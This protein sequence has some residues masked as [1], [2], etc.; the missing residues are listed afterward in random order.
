MPDDIAAAHRVRTADDALFPPIEARVSGRLKVSDLHD[1]YWEEAGSADGLP[2]V[3]L[4]GGPGAGISPKHRQFFD[5][6]A[7]RVVLHDQ[8]G[9]GR[10]TPFAEMTDNTTQHL[11]ADIERLRETRGIDKWVVFG[12]SWG[13]TLALAYAQAH[14]DRCLGLILRG[15][16]L[17][18]DSETDWFMYGLRELSPVAWRE[19][20]ALIPEAER[21]DLLGAY[22]RRLCD[23]DPAVNEPAGV[24][25]SLYEAR[26]STLY[27]EPALEAEMT[28]PAK[29]LA[30]SRIEAGYFVEKLFLE[31]GQLLRDVG[32]I[33]HLPA[34]IVQGRYDLL[35][36]IVAAEALHDAWPEAEY[37]LIPDAGH[38][39]FEPSIARALVA[40]TNRMAARLK[41]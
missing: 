38:S 13:S 10:S 23:P 16:F 36:P 1:L 19:F 21:G 4:H 26:S 3:F 41:A 22:Y 18:E 15:I 35:C 30:I 29:A 2:V 32:K 40:A 39:A 17:G 34:T 33:R 20:A 14:P 11:I 7:W 12:G 6:A 25:W 28:S 8:R 9:A 5:P 37:E 31:P 27:P 24:A